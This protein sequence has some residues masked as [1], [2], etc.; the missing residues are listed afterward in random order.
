MSITF[1]I[2]V[3]FIPHSTEMAVNFSVDLKQ[4]TSSRN[5]RNLLLN[6]HPTRN[7]TVHPASY[8]ITVGHCNLS[9]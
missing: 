9:V 7:L 8:Q 2:P 4:Y 1:L 5:K 6:S 3:C